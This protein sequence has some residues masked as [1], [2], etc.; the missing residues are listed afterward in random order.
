[1]H[2]ILYPVLAIL[3]V[4]LGAGLIFMPEKEND[5]GIDPEQLL[6]ELDNQT[7]FVT[8]DQVAEWIINEDPSVLLIDVRKEEAYQKY[9]LQGALHVPLENILGDEFRQYLRND[10]LTLVFYSNSDVE[11]QNAWM[12]CRRNEYENIYVLKGGL[13]HWV[14]TILNPVEPPVSA[15]QETFDLYSFRKAAC[16]YFSGASKEI[17]PLEYVEKKTPVI[18]KPV[19]KKSVKVIPKKIVEE[20]EEEGC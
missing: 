10:G 13:N 19:E 15:S 6:L 7:R 16:K 18:R 17:V 20:E 2:R 1:M 4:L 12:I 14:E 11:A 8:T 3:I 9:S 5:K